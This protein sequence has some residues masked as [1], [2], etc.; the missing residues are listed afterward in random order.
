MGSSPTFG[1]M[2][3]RMHWSERGVAQPGRAPRS[4]RGG[5]RF[6][7]SRPDQGLSG[8]CVFSAQ[9]PLSI[10]VAESALGLPVTSPRHVMKVRPLHQCMR[11]VFLLFVVSALL[12][13][14]GD[15]TADLP[16]RPTPFPTLERLP[17]V[18]PVTPSPTVPPTVT[19]VPL[20]TPTPT[21]LPAIA[22]TTANLRSN[23]SLDSSV[24]AVVEAG[25]S[26][27]LRARQGDWYAVELPGGLSGWMANTVLAIDPAV[28]AVVPEVQ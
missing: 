8:V 17:S 12:S 21:P 10:C 9:A 13:A 26:L 7:S 3:T 28:A 19:L 14:C 24:V 23:P 6:E 20:A 4:G 18:T 2:P 22:A 25:Q 5:R 11:F 27:N 15:L 1:T 16:P